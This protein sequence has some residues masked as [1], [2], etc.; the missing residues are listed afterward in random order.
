MKIIK[1]KG[2]NDSE[3]RLVVLCDK[4]FLSLWSYPNPI[5]KGK[6]P[7][8]LA[9]LL[10]VCGNDVLIFSDKQ[11][12]YPQIADKFIAWKRW[13]NKAICKSLQQ[14]Y[15]AE[16]RILNNPEKI[17]L[18]AKYNQP[19]PLEIPSK[20]KIKIHLICVANGAQNE[21]KKFFGSNC[22]GSLIFKTPYVL[23]DMEKV[24]TE[25]GVDKDYLYCNNLFSITDY[26]PN[27]TFVHVFDDYTLSLILN[28]IDTISDFIC[29]LT[30]KEEFLRK[31]QRVI[32]MGEEDLLVDYLSSY[33][34][35]NQC[36][37]FTALKSAENSDFIYI[38]EQNLDDFLSSAQF[39]AKAKEDEISYLWDNYINFHAKEVLDDLV[40][41]EN[42]EL[43]SKNEG[44]LKYMA[45]ENRLGR[46]ALSIII[47][48]AIQ[49]YPETHTELYRYCTCFFSI[50]IPN[51][52]YI[53]LQ[54]PRNVDIGYQEYRER[55]KNQLSMFVFC[56]KSKCIKEGIHIDKIIGIALE[57]PKLK[58]N[59]SSSEFIL[60]EIDE[61]TDVEQ[62]YYENIRNKENILRTPF[63]KANNIYIKEYPDID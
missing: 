42:Y 12:E 35:I 50:S 44:A 37:T 53:F 46:R 18:D 56:A 13:E 49:N 41:K 22:S 8:E 51:L 28:K 31:F 33:D 26:E 9:D 29:Y 10:V 36:H 3:N 7:K 32:Y 25:L 24:Q 52:L 23:N 1:S 59:I 38:P 60:Y 58:N 39:K 47:S 55:R 40:V 4:I 5:F 54:V 34:E 11:I 17:Y 45:L 30:K 61:W 57:P 2:I 43:N 19:F 48:R 15:Q 14:L 62:E 20:E 16:R 63:S 6:K 27:K 21:C